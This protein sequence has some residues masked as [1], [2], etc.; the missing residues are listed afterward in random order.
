MT[1]I[2]DINKIRKNR[3]W[4]REHMDGHDFLFQSMTDR[5]IENLRDIKRNFQNILIIGERGSRHIARHFDKNASITIYDII[6]DDDE[7][8]TLSPQTYDCV[9]CMGYLHGV[10]DVKKLLDIIKTSLKDELFWWA[11]PPRTP[12]F[13]FKS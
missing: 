10:N 7:I 6:D 3:L 11:Q 4:A 9:I 8:P 1:P 12:Q 2:F 5:I 13:Y